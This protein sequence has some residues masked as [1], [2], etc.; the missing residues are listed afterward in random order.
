MGSS[1]SSSCGCAPWPPAETMACSSAAV[2]GASAAPPPN[3]LASH[4][5]PI[6]SIGSGRLRIVICL[7]FGSRS[8][9]SC[10]APGSAWSAWSTVTGWRSSSSRTARGSSASRSCRVIRRGSSKSSAS[11]VKRISAAATARLPAPR[12]SA[13]TASCAI[14]PRDGS[15]RGGTWPGDCH[16]SALRARHART[17]GDAR[18]PR[19]RQSSAVREN[20]ARSPSRRSASQQPRPTRRAHGPSRHGVR[21]LRGAS[22]H[23]GAATPTRRTSGC[24]HRCATGV[25]R[26]RSASL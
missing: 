7:A 17:R 11:S 26:R 1:G 2:A 22:T 6:S 8:S 25:A 14:R 24:S 9:A 4:R 16:P 20:H 21:G 23:Q 15:A 13:S 10:A 5:M 3:C 18:R 19:T 12:C